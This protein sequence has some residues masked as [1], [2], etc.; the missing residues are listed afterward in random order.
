MSRLEV[1]DERWGL[2]RSGAW[3]GYALFSQ[4]PDAG[5]PVRASILSKPDGAAT[6]DATWTTLGS[7]R[8]DF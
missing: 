6:K 3:V 7:R 2:G 8:R 1:V 5:A 4:R